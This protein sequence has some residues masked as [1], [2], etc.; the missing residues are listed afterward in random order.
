MLTS[1]GA[2]SL[3]IR[4]NT[5]SA[6]SNFPWGSPPC[7]KAGMLAIAESG[8]PAGLLAQQAQEQVTDCL[9]YTSP[10]PRD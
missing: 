5:S 7:A 4:T 1:P 10:S 9:L 8:R 2:I 3:A 6:G